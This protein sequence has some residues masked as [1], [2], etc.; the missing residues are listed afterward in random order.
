MLTLKK[1]N[2][3]DMEKEYLFVRDMPADENGMT[4]PWHGVSREDFKKDVLPAV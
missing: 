2:F 3:E 1:A 4:N